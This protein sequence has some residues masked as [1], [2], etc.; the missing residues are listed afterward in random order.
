[1]ATLTYMQ[2]VARATWWEVFDEAP[3]IYEYNGWWVYGSPDGTDTSSTSYGFDPEL[4][5]ALAEL[6]AE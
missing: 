5:A 4:A 3:V 6:D 2:L 1:M